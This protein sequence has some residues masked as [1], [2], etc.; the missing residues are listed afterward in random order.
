MLSMYAQAVWTHV[1]QADKDIEHY[2]MSLQNMPDPCEENG[3]VLVD[4][5]SG[6]VCAVIFLTL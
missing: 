3:V 2:N 1:K 4:S 6:E 5:D